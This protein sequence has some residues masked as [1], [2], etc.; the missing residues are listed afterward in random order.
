MSRYM[1]GFTL[2]ERDAER[3][4]YAKAVALRQTTN[5]KGVAAAL[6]LNVGRVSALLSCP[7]W[8]EE[9]LD[10]DAEALSEYREFLAFHRAES[11]KAKREWREALRQHQRDEAHE[12]KAQSA[13]C[14][15]E[16]F[17]EMAPYV[18]TEA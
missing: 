2:A 17:V 9:R 15:I 14:L 5:V 18:G 7:P 10:R 13:V 12:V 6:G 4:L 3:A 8:S 11:R 1:R 16:A